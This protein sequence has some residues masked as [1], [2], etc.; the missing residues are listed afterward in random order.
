MNEGHFEIYLDGALNN[1]G[2]NLSGS[3]PIAGNGIFVVGQEQDSLGGGFSESESFVG[4]ISYL[5]LWSRQLTA[6]EINEY[7]RTC[8]PYQGDLNLTKPQDLI[9]N[10]EFSR[11]SLCVD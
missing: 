4:K 6:I 8:D 11:K 10:F 5:D 9:K 3:S 1:E 2:Y 7:Y